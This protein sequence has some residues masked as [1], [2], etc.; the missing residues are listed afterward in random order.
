ML[1][2][3]HGDTLVVAQDSSLL[4]YDVP[5]LLHGGSTEAFQTL[6]AMGGGEVIDVRWNPGITEAWAHS[7]AVLST[8]GLQLYRGS[9]NT[10]AYRSVAELPNAPCPIVSCTDCSAVGFPHLAHRAPA[11]R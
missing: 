9:E 4:L 5:S 1:A 11:A 2:D 8:G 6:A 3:S 10:N 7:F